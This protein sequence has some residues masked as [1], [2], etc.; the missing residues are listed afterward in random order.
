MRKGLSQSQ[1]FGDRGQWKIDDFQDVAA[2]QEIAREG[3][4]VAG[5][6]VDARDFVYAVRV[7]Y[8]RQGPDG[9]LAPKDTYKSEWLGRPQ[10]AAPRTLASDGSK[11]I[12]VCGRGA[13]VLDAI[14]LVL[15]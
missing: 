5:L 9:R 3:Y 7:I 14:G 2:G 11:V 6:E 12:G 15:E 13:A 4:A 10:G 8:M 1:E